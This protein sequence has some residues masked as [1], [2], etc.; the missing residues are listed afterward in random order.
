M[1]YADWCPSGRLEEQN[2]LNAT[3]STI[4]RKARLLESNRWLAVRYVAGCA[5]Y[6]ALRTEA[7]RDAYIPTEKPEIDAIDDDEP[8]MKE[9]VKVRYEPILGP[10]GRPIAMRPIRT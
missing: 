3:G 6:R 10:N 2:F 5:E 8:E 7:E 4:T 1:D 9:E